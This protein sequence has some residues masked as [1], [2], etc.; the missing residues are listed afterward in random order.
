MTNTPIWVPAHR[1]KN[2]GGWVADTAKVDELIQKEAEN[3]FKR[4][5]SRAVPGDYYAP[6]VFVNGDGEIGMNHFGYSL[7]NDC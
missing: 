3:E 7:R 5:L 4:E 1:H 2:G 6:S